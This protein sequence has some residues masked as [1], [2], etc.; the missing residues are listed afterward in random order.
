MRERVRAGEMCVC[1]NVSACVRE[2]VVRVWYTEKRELMRFLENCVRE[3][4]R[5]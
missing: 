5:M 3:E 2:S 4:V 1:V